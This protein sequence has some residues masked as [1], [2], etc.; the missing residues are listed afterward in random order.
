MFSSHDGLCTIGELAEYA[1]VSVKTVRFYSD[2]GLLP[3]ATRS[4]G[5]HRR[6]APE[7][8]ERLDL[9]RSLRGLGLPVADV[10]RILDKQD[11]G[12]AAHVLEAAV[13]E[14]LR[15]LGSELRALRWRE[16]ALQLVRDC[17][18]EERPA[19]LRLVGAVAAPPS[20]A[21]LVRFW[22]AWLPAR[23]PAPSVG[24]FLEAA[25]P[26]PPDDPRP[27]QV[28]A[29]ARLYAFVT[30]PC[31][32]SGGD[33]CQPRAHSTAGARE[34]AVLYAGLATAYDLAGGAMRQGAAPRPG[35]ALDGFVDAYAS[36]YSARDTPGFRR[37]LAGQ[38]AADPRIDRYW[39]LTAEVIGAPGDHAAPTPGTAH[40]WL[41]GA[42]DTDLSATLGEDDAQK[43]LS[44][45][46]GAGGRRG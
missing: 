22:R 8:V 9:I 33:P 34:S 29:F 21:A 31:E 1:G 10:R 12:D 25:V 6:Y 30:R 20:T 44:S 7:A 2:G 46:A 11:A 14:R 5:G 38:L 40:D 42:L 24:A 23:M 35:E 15:A 18:Q 4:A 16:A 41:L 27:E 45:T 39:E 43:A 26:Q 19:R 32:G 17:P 37:R 3:E 28:L 13:A 36:T